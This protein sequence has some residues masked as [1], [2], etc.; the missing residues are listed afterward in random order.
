MNVAP[1]QAARPTNPASYAASKCGSGYSL[2]H[3]Y[4][5]TDSQGII[6]SKSYVFWNGSS[7]KNCAIVLKWFEWGYNSDTYIDLSSYNSNGT[8]YQRDWDSGDYAYYAGPVYLY[9]PGRCV[10]ILSFVDANSGGARYTYD[11]PMVG[12]G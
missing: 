7:K 5:K 9:A 12:C 4:N 10:D 3:S 8:R 1:A 11:S 2:I 6:W